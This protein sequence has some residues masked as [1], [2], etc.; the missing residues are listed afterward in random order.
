MFLLFTIFLPPRCNKT[1]KNKKNG[2]INPPLKMSGKI[3]YYTFIYK[4]F[5]Q[6]LS[7]SLSI[8]LFLLF[9]DDVRCSEN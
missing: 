3:D 5:E 8:L 4:F 9:T 7:L 6:H 2:S 1:K